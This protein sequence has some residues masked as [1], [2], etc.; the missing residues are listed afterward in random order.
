MSVQGGFCLGDLCPGGLCK[1][2]SLSRGSLLGRPSRTETAGTVT[3]G[4]YASYWNAFLFVFHLFMLLCSVT[5]K[6]FK[7]LSL[8]LFRP[9]ISVSRLPAQGSAWV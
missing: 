2:G 4:R 7:R 3:S 1:V 5:S 6:S 9:K 8:D